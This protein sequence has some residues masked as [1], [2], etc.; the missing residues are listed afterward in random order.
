MHPQQYNKMLI[1]NLNGGFGEKPK[2]I[3]LVIVRLTKFFCFI[4]P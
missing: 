1:F 4:L 3:L 2:I